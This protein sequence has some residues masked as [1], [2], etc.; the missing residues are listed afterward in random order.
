[1]C[2]WARYPELLRHGR[3]YVCAPLRVGI[4]RVWMGQCDLQYKVLWV[5]KKVENRHLNAVHLHFFFFFG[6]Y[7]SQFNVNTCSPS[8]AQQGR[9]RTWRLS[10]LRHETRY[11]RCRHASTTAANQDM[12]CKLQQILKKPEWE[13]LLRHKHLHVSI[14][15]VRSAYSIS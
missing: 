7:E 1:M 13:Y 4:L 10:K 9:M 15:P 14:T 5:V 2:P 6:F 8:H 3:V 12:C 11:K